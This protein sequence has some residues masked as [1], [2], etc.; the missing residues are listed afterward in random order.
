MVTRKLRAG[1]SGPLVDI[2][3]PDLVAA[4]RVVYVNSFTE[5]PISLQTGS[6]NLP[7]ATLTQAVNALIATGGVIVVAPG[8]Y[9]T[10]SLPALTAGEWTI[11][12]VDPHPIYPIS[13]IAPNPVSLPTITGT[14]LNFIGCQLLGAINATRVRLDSCEVQ[15]TINAY[16]IDGFDTNFFSAGSVINLTTG[17]MTLYECALNAAIITASAGLIVRLFDCFLSASLT[18]TSPVTS[19]L[20]VDQHTCAAFD[21]FIPTLTNTNLIVEGVSVGSGRQILNNTAAGSLGVID[22]S[23]LQPGGAL[24]IQPTA[25]FSIDGFTTKQNGFWFDLIFDSQ[26]S[27][28]T[29]TLVHEAAGATTSIRCPNT[30]SLSFNRNTTIRLRYQFNRWRVGQVGVTP[31]ALAQALNNQ[32]IPFVISSTFAAGGGG[33]ADDVTILAANLLP[34]NIR[35]ID[36]WLDTGTAVVGATGQLRSATGG[37]GNALSSAMS[38][39]AANAT[40]RSSVANTTTATV[41][42]NG[43]VFLRRSDSGFSG[44]AFA[45]CIRT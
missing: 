16:A 38:A 23:A 41:A 3:D 7:Y 11:T 6:P 18:M 29:G 32:A 42:A 35:V 36:A 20:R 25:N 31:A 28:F 10:E 24:V 19:T 13:G 12:N 9:S 37:G 15:A 45:L 33:A 40:S 8:N 44:E 26:A 39:A 30:S 27:L 34:F 17:G 5:L 21:A 43:G 2:I 22:I 1:P 14:S 4:S